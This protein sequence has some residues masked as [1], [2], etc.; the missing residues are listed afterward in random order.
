MR[1]S[2]SEELV[3]QADLPG[4]I[5]YEQV[6]RSN[7]LMKRVRVGL[8]LLMVT[9][10][11]GLIKIHLDEEPIGTS[12]EQRFT[13]AAWD[14]EPQEYASFAVI[15]RATEQEPIRLYTTP[16]INKNLTPDSPTNNRAGRLILP[17]VIKQPLFVNGMYLLD[18]AYGPVDSADELADQSLWVSDDIEHQQTEAGLPYAAIV[19]R[20][21]ESIS[22]QTATLDPE[23]GNFLDAEDEVVGRQMYAYTY[24]ELLYRLHEEGYSESNCY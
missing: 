23:T 15:L 7:R 2:W 12:E 6:Q 5:Q 8:A 16:E 21:N 3:P 18:D 20:R 14:G 17:L 1:V 13:E 19:C 10:I 24:D 22:F 4:G 9:G 11:A